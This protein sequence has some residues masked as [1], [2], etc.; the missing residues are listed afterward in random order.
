M[1][2]RGKEEERVEVKGRLEEGLLE[3]RGE[4]WTVAGTAVERGW[5][6]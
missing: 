3:L 4:W 6:W 1:R 5:W 2:E